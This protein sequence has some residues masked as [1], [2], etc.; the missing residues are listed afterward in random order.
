M[1]ELARRLGSDAP[2]G[3]SASQTQDQDRIRRSYGSSEASKQED[4]LLAGLIA[5][6]SRIDIVREILEPDD[7]AVFLEM[8]DQRR[9]IDVVTV[10]GESSYRG[11]VTMDNQAK[12]F[13]KLFGSDQAVSASQLPEL[14]LEIAHTATLAYA[15][16][17][18]ARLVDALADTRLRPAELLTLTARELDGLSARQNRHRFSYQL[19][20]QEDQHSPETRRMSK[21]T[22]I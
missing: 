5:A 7:F 22:S 19:N 14:A 18:T 15:G 16:A 12:S 21:P 20:G 2:V 9:L 13:R 1:T 10:L 6:S 3:P 11:I 4:A 17:A 8:R